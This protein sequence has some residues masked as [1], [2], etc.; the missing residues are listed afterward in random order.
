[1]SLKIRVKQIRLQLI[2]ILLDNKR[3]YII[4]TVKSGL[5]MKLETLTYLILL[6]NAF[7][8]DLDQ[9]NC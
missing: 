1:M 8:E 6:G 7:F 2:R 5:T 3:N 9:M 4:F